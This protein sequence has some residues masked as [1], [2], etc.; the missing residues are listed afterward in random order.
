MNE[1]LKAFRYVV[2]LLFLGVFIRLFYWQIIKSSDLQVIAQS[3]YHRTSAIPVSRGKLYSSA[4]YPLAMNQHVLTLYALP[5]TLEQST[6]SS[7]N[8]LATTLFGEEARASSSATPSLQT[9][10]TMLLGKLSD[11]SKNWVSLRNH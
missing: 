11:S 6:A 7:A 8:P 10:R 5:K 2:L 1:R 3:Q 9:F 4:R